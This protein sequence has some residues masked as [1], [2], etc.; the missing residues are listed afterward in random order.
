[1]PPPRHSRERLEAAIE[2]RE[3]ARPSL[4]T[5]IEALRVGEAM[6]LSVEQGRTLRALGA[7]EGALEELDISVNEARRALGLSVTPV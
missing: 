3:Q 5:A 4:L 6:P 2:W 1:M 7:A